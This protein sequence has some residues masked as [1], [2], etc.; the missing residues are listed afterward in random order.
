MTSP[1]HVCTLFLQER[2]LG[3]DGRYRKA[4]AGEDPHNIDISLE[5]VFGSVGSFDQ[6]NR[7]K[8]KL[9][10]GEQTVSLKLSCDLLLGTSP[11]GRH[12]RYLW[13]P[14]RR[15]HALPPPANA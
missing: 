15:M 14:A 13:T 10:L 9:C 4:E 8:V 2:L 6:N 5:Y 1:S 11:G 3:E 12:C 7:D